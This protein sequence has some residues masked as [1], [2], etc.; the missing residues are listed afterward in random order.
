MPNQEQKQAAEKRYLKSGETLRALAAGMNVD[1]ETVKK[2]SREGKWAEKKRRAGGAAPRLSAKEKQLSKL[3]EASDEIEEALQ[4]AA[5]G[6]KRK[7]AEDTDGTEI[8]DGK[9][10]AGNLNSIAHAIDRQTKTR[11]LLSSV[12][13]KEGSKESVKFTME[14]GTEQLSE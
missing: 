4:M 8:A 12:K 10:R 6:L 7:M 9:F 5:M 1:Y 2:W 13:P 3:M 11:I 14:A